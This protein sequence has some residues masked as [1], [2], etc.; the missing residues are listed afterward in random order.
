MSVSHSTGSPTL[1]RTPAPGAARIDENIKAGK[2]DFSIAAVKDQLNT[3]LHFVSKIMTVPSRHRHY[4][5]YEHS[6]C[7]MGIL[8]SMQTQWLAVPSITVTFRSPC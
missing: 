4:L 6:I 7:Y 8:G 2:E 5:C 3:L 1:R